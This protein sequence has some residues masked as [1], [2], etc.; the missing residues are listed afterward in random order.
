MWQKIHG[1]VQKSKIDIPEVP[2]PLQVRC[3]DT[4]AAAA[5]LLASSC[6]A[7]RSVLHY[8]SFSLAAAL[9]RLAAP[10]SVAARIKAQEEAKVSS[11][12]RTNQLPLQKQETMIAML[13]S[14]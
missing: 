2:L 5:P 12:A 7:T 3:W 14:F 9:R 4:D 13:C 11:P 6:S 10:M 8:L 1:L